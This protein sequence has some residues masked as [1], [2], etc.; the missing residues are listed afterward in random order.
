MKSTHSSKNQDREIQG[1]IDMQVPLASRHIT[2]ITYDLKSRA[3]ITNGN[4]LVK[5]NGHQ[6]LDGRYTSKSES[7]AGV[8]RD[9]VDIALKNDRLPIGISYSHQMSGSDV[10]QFVSIKK[11]NYKE[12]QVYYVTVYYYYRI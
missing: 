3:A 1:T 11:S 2:A 4:C 7:H 6:V 10:H 8:D 5:Y 12:E 9:V